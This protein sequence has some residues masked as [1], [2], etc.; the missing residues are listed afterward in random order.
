MAGLA[1]GSPPIQGISY[2]AIDRLLQKSTGCVPFR[3]KTLENS[4]LPAK[5]QLKVAD[6]KKKA[7]SI[8]SSLNVTETL[9]MIKEQMSFADKF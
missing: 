4:L 5:A 8:I 6:V 9:D 7:C 3:H 1:P 2:Y